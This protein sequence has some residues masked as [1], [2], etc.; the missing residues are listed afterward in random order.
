MLQINIMQISNKVLL[1]DD[2]NFRDLNHLSFIG[3]K[4]FSETLAKELNN[5]FKK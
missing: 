5:I 4:R 2:E 1:V 3:R